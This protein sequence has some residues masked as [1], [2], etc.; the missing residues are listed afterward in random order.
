MPSDRLI[1]TKETASTP[2]HGNSPSDARSGA[3]NLALSYKPRGLVKVT[4]TTDGAVFLDVA[5]GTCFSVSVVGY[6][7][8]TLLEK[9][10][11]GFQVVDELVREFSVPRE[12]VVADT[13]EFLTSLLSLNLI[14][15][16]EAQTTEVKKTARWWRV[17]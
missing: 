12:E 8:W 11:T 5:Q 16:P 10:S 4:A 17:W 6:R 7:I 1:T 14:S 9:G 13:G 3:A 2:I 15:L